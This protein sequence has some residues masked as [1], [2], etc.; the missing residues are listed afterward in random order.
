MEHEC[1]TTPALPLRWSLRYLRS[2][3]ASLAEEGRT[4]CAACGTTARAAIEAAAPNDGARIT[5]GG[6][7]PH[8]LDWLSLRERPA[9]V[10]HGSPDEG[11]HNMFI[12]GY[13]RRCYA[14]VLY[15]SGSTW[16][17]DHPDLTR[18]SDEEQVERDGE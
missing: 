12:S 10:W 8:P 17:A 4:A 1:T 3:R 13:C 18:V 14:V 9:L 2:I 5:W 7:L 16:S 6:Q 11:E 15:D